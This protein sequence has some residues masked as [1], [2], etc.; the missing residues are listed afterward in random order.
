MREREIIAPMIQRIDGLS[1]TVEDIL[2]FARPNPPCHRLVDVH[3]L[4]GD[5]IASARAGVSDPCIAI[6]LTGEN[7]TLWADPD[8]IRA[9]LLNLVLN[10]CQA[11]AGRP[12]EIATSV[13]GAWCHVQVLDR[14][15]GIPADVQRRIFEPF[16][17]T[18]SSGTGLGL[19][20]VRRLMDIQGG[21]VSLRP[22]EGG[23]TVAE[24]AFPLKPD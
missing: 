9:V 15:S 6:D 22:R 21:T 14:G 11:S 13:K 5:V 12:V 17:T 4:V 7:T 16:F 8:M 18:K 3:A 19:P 2:L 10:A 20:I 24:V 1:K 23:G